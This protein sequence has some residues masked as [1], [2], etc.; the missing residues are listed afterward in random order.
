M[1]DKIQTK[2]KGLVVLIDPESSKIR[3]LDSLVPFLNSKTVDFLFLGGSFLYEN[4]MD[5][6]IDF[7]KKHTSQ[8]ILLFP[9]DLNQINNKADGILLLSLISGRN[10]DLLIGKQ[11]MAAP[12]L[13]ASGLEILSTGYMLIEGG[14]YTTAHYI[15]QTMPIPREK[16]EIAAATALAGQMLGMKLIYMDAGSGAQLCI[17]ENLIAKVSATIDIPLV[18]GG[19]INTLDK[20]ENAWNAGAN[21]VVIGNALE[22][23]P[24]LLETFFL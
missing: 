20:A 21:F 19:G 4:E 16:A 11:V 18:V 3:N 1:L 15:S 7:L 9:G 24:R 13:K 8:P 12:Q 17:P 2:G 10:P 23:N 6:C 14:Q 22:Q 5:R